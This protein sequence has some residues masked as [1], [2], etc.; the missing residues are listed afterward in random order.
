M[1]RPAAARQ[2]AKKSP[3][4]AGAV[5]LTT[6]PLAAV[7][8]LRSSAIEGTKTG[9]IAVAA[10][11]PGEGRDGSTLAAGEP[12][13]GARRWLVATISR[14][15]ALAEAHAA[16]PSATAAD[17]RRHEAVRPLPLPDVSAPPR[18]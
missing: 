1:R 6:R 17:E 5:V 16:S 15:E 13:L 2:D 14:E 7:D 3:W 12:V 10:A 4:R 11:P 9:R 18:R 8:P